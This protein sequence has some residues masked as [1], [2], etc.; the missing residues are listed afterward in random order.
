MQPILSKPIGSATISI[1]V[2]AAQENPG[3]RGNPVGLT[4][5]HDRSG[6][7]CDLRHQA[8]RD[9]EDCRRAAGEGEEKVT[10]LADMPLLTKLA[11]VGFVLVM[12]SLPFVCVAV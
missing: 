8:R 6:G 5:A 12:V 3:R 1:H 11:A 2:Q 10:P 7:R 4:P 9:G